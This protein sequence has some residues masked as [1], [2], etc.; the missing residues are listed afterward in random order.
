VEPVENVIFTSAEDLGASCA[1][2]GDNIIILGSIRG[3]NNYSI[4]SRYNAYSTDDVLDN[5]YS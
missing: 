5:R 1:G 3:R 2:D 4:D